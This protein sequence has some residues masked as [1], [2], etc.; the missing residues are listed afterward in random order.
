MIKILSYKSIQYKKNPPHDPFNLLQKKK[1]C[2]QPK[3]LNGSVNQ[4]SN[5][6]KL[7]H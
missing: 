4:H 6:T 3:L 5:D 1:T 2:P 7:S